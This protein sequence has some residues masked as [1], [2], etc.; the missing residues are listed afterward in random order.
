MIDGTTKALLFA[1]ALGLWANVLTQWVPSTVLQAQDF[2][3]SR[4]VSE[5]IEIEGNTRH[6]E[7]YLSESMSHLLQIRSNTG[8]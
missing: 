8:F 6:L 2:D 4:I 5:L 3:D 1:L 7:S